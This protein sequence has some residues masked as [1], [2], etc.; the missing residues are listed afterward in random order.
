MDPAPLLASLVAHAVPGV[1]E[2]TIDSHDALGPATG[3]VRRLLHVGGRLVPVTA[4]LGHDVVTMAVET[5]VE[6]AVEP[7]VEP[8][9]KPAGAPPTPVVGA[10][11]AAELRAAATRWF[12]LD[13]EPAAVAAGLAGD[14]LLGPLVTRRPALRVLGHLDGFEAAVATVLG[15][16]VS[17][18]AA[19]VFTG[20]LA[21]AY[22]TAGSGGLVA[23]PRPDRL[24]AADAAEVQQAVRIT[25][26]RARTIVGLAAACA[27]GLVLRPGVDPAST[28]ARLLALPGIGPWTADYL[29]LRVLADRDAFPSGDLVLRRALGVT[30]PLEAEAAGRAWRPW[31][32]YATVHLWT[33]RV[34]GL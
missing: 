14:P 3:T 16:Q 32:A 23:F 29:A 27:D 28:R 34:Y 15:Q 11:E 20:R 7:A 21:A 12:G 24:A 25:A 30:T 5:A 19:R 10:P 22:G 18:A 9:P 1:E 13:D 33:N 6:T 8:S 26:A 2:V 17:L 4:T 31:R